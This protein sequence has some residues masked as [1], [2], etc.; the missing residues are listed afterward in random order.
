[1]S[2]RNRKSVQKRKVSDVGHNGNIAA[3]Y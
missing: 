2:A 1:L 3:K